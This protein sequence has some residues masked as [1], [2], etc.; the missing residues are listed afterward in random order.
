MSEKNNPWKTLSQREVY[1]SPWI[2]VTEHQV[3]NPANREGIYSVVNFKNVAVGIIPLSDDHHTWL[4]GQY[5][6]PIQQYTWE[7]PEGGAPPSKPLLESA[8]RELREETGITAQQWEKVQEMYLSNSATDERAVIY[9]AQNLTFHTP[10][11]EETEELALQKVSLEEALEMVEQGVIND[12]I[13]VAA[14]LKLK[15]QLSVS[16]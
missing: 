3:I 10:E 5:R 13:S 14:F 8:K 16:S 11:P 15:D 9:L 6:Y 4:V 1:D 2:K 7:I 12:A